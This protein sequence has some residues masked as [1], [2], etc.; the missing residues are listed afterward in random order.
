[1]QIELISSETVIRLG[2]FMIIRG[3]I[4]RDL[5]VF[6]IIRGYIIRD[7]FVAL[8]QNNL[9]SVS[10]RCFTDCTTRNAVGMAVFVSFFFSCKKQNSSDRGKFH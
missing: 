2:V 6:M 8:I 1:M 4:I 5:F 10:F 7:L 9:C 3:Y